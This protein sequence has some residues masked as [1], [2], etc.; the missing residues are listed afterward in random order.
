MSD[1]KTQRAFALADVLAAIVAVVL[2]TGAVIPVVAGG[3]GDAMI[4]ESM[5]N[6]KLLGF[7]HVLYAAEW[8]G[9]QITFAKDDLSL[10]G[11][12]VGDY[13]NNHDCGDTFDPGC[14]PPVLAGWCEGGLYA[15]W[16]ESQ[17]HWWVVEP[18]GFPDGQGAD[19][20][21][22][23][24]LLNSSQFHQYV[25]GRF[26]DAAFYA[27]ADNVALDLAEPLFDD[28]NEF[29]CT[30]G[31][32]PPIWIS[33]VMSPAAM[34][35][36]D[37]MRS[38]AAGGWQDPWDIDHGH[39]SPGFFQADFPALKTLM[40]EHHWLQGRPAECNPNA[41]VAFGT[42]DGCEPYYFNHGLDSSPVTLFYD[43]SVR[44]LPNAEVLAADQQV[45]KDTGGVDGL[46]HRGTSF[47]E[48]GYY[49][50]QGYDGVPLSHHI[51]TTDG[52]KGRDTLG[53]QRPLPIGDFDWPPPIRFQADRNDIKRQRSFASFVLTP[54]EEI[55]P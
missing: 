18:I 25:N 33:Y 52:I 53:E 6:L 43:L 8:D 21:G 1:P 7:A 34:F 40:I 19:G 17:N 44:Q 9:R 41:D 22:H 45:L 20:F 2:L 35:H 24:R 3:R 27:P 38:N 42:F 55:D 30:A 37:V 26:Y 14:H 5:N 50:S 51:L 36:P 11:H 28:P 4:E 48:N 47:G 49:I 31:G 12:N 39:E 32:N 23:F 29:V 54:Q 13:N 10:F 15:Y 46:W 16:P